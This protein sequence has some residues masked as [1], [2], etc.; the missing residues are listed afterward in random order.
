MTWR[1]CL[2]RAKSTATNETNNG[3][4]FDVNCVVESGKM[5]IG[6]IPDSTGFHGILR[7]STDIHRSRGIGVKFHQILV[8]FKVNSTKF[9]ELLIPVAQRTNTLRVEFWWNHGGIPPV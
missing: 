8:E 7:D 6:Y 3:K 5:C 1:G 2:R 4:H 9:V